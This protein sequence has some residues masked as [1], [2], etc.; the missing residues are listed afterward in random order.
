MTGLAH[1]LALSPES[2]SKYY[3]KNQ[4]NLT[5]HRTAVFREEQQI[6]FSSRL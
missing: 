1:L 2:S 4:N 5:Q 6:P 3:Q